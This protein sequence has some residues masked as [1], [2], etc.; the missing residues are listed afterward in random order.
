MLAGAEHLDPTEP[1]AERHL[2][3]VV[4]VQVAEH[5]H[6]VGV[7]RVERPGRQLVVVEQPVDVDAEHLG[8]H[9]LGQLR[10]LDRQRHRGLSCSSRSSRLSTL[11]D[12]L[13]GS[14]SRKVTSFG[15]LEAGQLGPAVLDQLVGAWRS[16]P[17]AGRRTPPAPRPSARRGG[18]TTAASSTGVVLVEHALDL[19]AGDVL[20]ARH[21]HVLE[22]VDDE[23][24]AVVVAHADVAGVEPAAG[25]R[26]GGRVGVA[27]VAL[28]HLRAPHDDLAP[29]P[30]RHRACPRRPRCR[31]RGRGRGGRRCR[32]W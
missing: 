21:D 8:A 10:G 27:P 19:G 13:R 20:A 14:A 4:D 17:G 29:L 11:P 2:G 22:P 18:P 15:D 23:E 16:R 12:G 26:G 28:E 9:R 24:V 32:A 30:R 6:A 7:E 1:L 25:E 5:E 3:R 31:A